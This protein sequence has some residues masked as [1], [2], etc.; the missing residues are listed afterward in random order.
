MPV[1]I[2]SERTDSLVAQSWKLHRCREDLLTAAADPEFLRHSW[3]RRLVSDDQDPNVVAAAE[4]VARNVLECAKAVFAESPPPV[5]LTKIA[6]YLGVSLRFVAEE[7]GG[8]YEPQIA[9]SDAGWARGVLGPN[10]SQRWILHAGTRKSTFTRQTVAH[11]LGHVLLFQRENQIDFEAW[12]AATWSDAEESIVNYLARL[13]LA[14]TDLIQAAGP[15]ANLAV[16]V[17]QAIA[18]RFHIP[19]RVAAV[20][21]LDD[22]AFGGEQLRA[23]VMWRQYHPLSRAYI[24]TCFRRWPQ[25]TKQLLATVEALSSFTDL[26]KFEKA[27]GAL[28]EILD[29]LED[30][31]ELSSL[32]FGSDERSALKWAREKLSLPRDDALSSRISLSLD[33]TCHLMFRPEWVV[34]RGRPSRS[35]VPLHRGHLRQGSIAARLA[36]SGVRVD[37]IAHERVEIGDLKGFFRVHAFGHGDPH[38]GSR[39]IIGALE[40]VPASAD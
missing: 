1:V 31:R 7:Q 18:N 27:L 39:F 24:R 6:E 14:P 29:P 20:R 4:A 25:V 11:E 12:Q 3:V 38:E 21:C 5:H 32:R 9:R 22:P 19:H 8:R 40:D 30:E 23:V 16:H 15:E 26:T 28:R 36:S 35:F 37:T 17:V 2:G 10:T 33:P 13:L 34:W